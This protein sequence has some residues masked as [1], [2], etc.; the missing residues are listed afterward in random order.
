MWPFNKRIKPI[1]SWKE[2]SKEQIIAELNLLKRRDGLHPKFELLAGASYWDDEVP[3]GKD[4]G[5]NTAC[6]LYLRMAFAYRHSIAIGS[7]RN[8]LLEKWERLKSEVPNW[9][10]FSKERIEGL[11]AK[12]A[13][14]CERQMRRSFEEA[15]MK[16]DS[17]DKLK[18]NTT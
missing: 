3:D 16:M 1:K 11:S 6:N 15:E 10:G 17:E 9:P 18:E 4:V 5:L 7:P 8:D 2:F 12:F 13:K 14:V